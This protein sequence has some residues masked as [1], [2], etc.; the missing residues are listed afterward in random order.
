[1]PWATE[2]V[3]IPLLLFNPLHADIEFSR[4]RNEMDHDQVPSLW[5]YESV[6]LN[7]SKAGG[8]GQDP[9]Y[10]VEFSK[11]QVKSVQVKNKQTDKEINKDIKQRKQKQNKQTKNDKK[12]ENKLSKSF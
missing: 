2:T 7:I 11:R 3:I 9:S 10:C 5:R 6:E 4:R 12:H 1:M 8:V